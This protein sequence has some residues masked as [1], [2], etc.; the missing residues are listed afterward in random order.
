[1]RSCETSTVLL[2]PFDPW[3][4][5][6]ISFDI[7]AASHDSPEAL[8][9]RQSHRLAELL[10]LAA[11]ASPMYRRLFGSRSATPPLRE[12]PVMTKRKLMSRF[13]EWVTD[14]LLELDGLR[15]FIADPARIGQPYLDRYAVWESSGSSG[16]PGVFVQDPQAL[17]VTHALEA[18]RPAPLQPLRRCWDP[19]YLYERMAFVGATTGHF[20]STVSVERMRHL[21]PSVAATVRSFSFLQST[22]ELVAQ[23][24]DHAPTIIATYP[25]AA[26]MLA[27]QAMAGRLRIP[28]HEMWTG[29][30]ALTPQVRRFVGE[31]FKC[32]VSN[33]YGASEFLALA[34]ECR[35]ARLHLNSDWAVLESV[36]ARGQ[37]VPAGETGSTTLLTN[38]ANHVQPV[39]R[40]DLGDRVTMARERCSCGSVF[41][42]LE[43]Q[44]RVDDTLLFQD[45][46]HHPVRLLPLALTTV[47]EDDA[48]VFDFQIEQQSADSLLLRLAA[49]GAV[50]KGELQRAR[51]ALR[52]FLRKQGLPNVHVHAHCG[53][54][55]VRGRS[56]KVPRIIGSAGELDVRATTTT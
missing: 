10:K 40:Y 47:L 36:D 19:Y 18:V 45:R 46:Q 24:N 20:A 29:G 52:A 33:S 44:G 55:A 1:V 43:V 23:L 27:E 2:S 16:E 35:C 5:S 25:T 37:A 11:T 9:R 21:N 54:P 4:A 15:R 3:R 13:E 38:L 8:Q 26:L 32:P 42:V 6:A 28:L 49:N 53:E 34:F 39:I 51:A 41:P 56:G 31:A 48:Q 22:A 30:E 14:P 12:W 50:G 7:I 17:A